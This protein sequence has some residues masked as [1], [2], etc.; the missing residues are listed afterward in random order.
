MVFVSV[1]DHLQ[2]TVDHSGTI[3]DYWRFF[4]KSC[5]GRWYSP[6]IRGGKDMPKEKRNYNI[7]SNWKF[8]YTELFHFDKKI[9]A[10][11]GAE[12]ILQVV[13]RLVLVLL[14]AFVIHLLEL[15]VPIENMATSILLAFVG[16]GLIS[17]LAT[18]FVNRNRGQY[19]EFRGGS[20]MSKLTNKVSYLDYVQLENEDTQKLMGNAI[21]AVG[22]NNDGLEGIIHKTTKLAT[23]IL[24]LGCFSLFMAN[25]SIWIVALLIMVS[26]IQVYSYKLASKYVLKNVSVKAEYEVTKNYFKRQVYDVNSGKDI[27]IYQLKNWLT[28]AYQ[29]AN[30]KYQK[31]VAKEKLHYFANDLICLILQLARDG[32]CYYY[33]I[34]LLKNGMGVAEFVLYMGIIAAFSTYFNE[35]TV[36]LMGFER[37]QISLDFYRDFINMKTIFNHGEGEKLDQ[38][39]STYAIEFSKVSFSY[40]GNEDGEIQQKI[41]D[42]VS[43]TINEGEKLALV[44]TN[45]AGKSTIVKLLCGFYVPDSGQIRINGVDL[46]EMDLDDYYRYLAV[47]FQESFVYSF[48]L[49]ENISCQSLEDSDGKRVQHA[50]MDSGL[51]DKIKSL[52]K[53]ELTYLNKN[54]D[55]EGIQLSGGEMQKLMLARALYKKCKL[56]ILDEPTAALDALAESEMYEKYEQVISGKSALFISH[57]LASTKF[58]HKI[59]YLEQGKVI[60]RGTHEELMSLQGQYAT[61]FEVQSKYYKED[62]ENEYE[63]IS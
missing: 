32:S 44:G 57:R 31:I 21:N 45:G 13:F 62:K 55:Q 54:I 61:M 16:F 3:G 60:E 41:L 39:K 20:M 22:S 24:S 47:V 12:V 19:V 53:K 40:P 52:P 30:Q 51:W 49:T 58:C 36:Q 7:F 23:A 43:F 18:W 59:I 17:S 29:R 1:G 6:K 50:L 37:D 46:K 42:E 28:H 11:Q 9:I 48:T 25:L 56:L 8:I 14:P 15:K 35:I 63:I 2:I 26:V 27:R 4:E 33:F 38:N 34:Q 5:I 10:F